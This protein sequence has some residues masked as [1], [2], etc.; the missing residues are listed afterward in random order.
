MTARKDKAP[1]RKWSDAKAKE[2]VQAYF[3]AV[4]AG[5]AGKKK[6][7]RDILMKY[8]I[9]RTHIYHW[10]TKFGLAQ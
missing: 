8:R 2:L 9:S 7:G 4:A 1:Q 5:K 6:R 10:A 3:A